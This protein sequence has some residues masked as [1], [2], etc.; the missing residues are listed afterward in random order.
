M[1]LLRRI[2]NRHILWVALSMVA[3]GL[4]VP[5]GFGVKPPQWFH[6]RPPQDVASLSSDELDAADTSTSVASLGMVPKVE[7]NL[8]AD[9]ATQQAPEPDQTSPAQTSQ[10]Q[11]SQNQPSQNQTSAVT[12]P[13]KFARHIPAK[14]FEMTGDIQ[15]E[16]FIKLVLPLILAANEE[17]LQRREAV[18]AAVQA[19]DRDTLVQWAVL[20]RID[21]EDFDD[22]GLA[23]RLLRRVDTI[24]VALALAQA[25]V[26]SGWGTSRF[27]RQGNA[28]FGQWAWTESAGLRP[29]AASN[30]RAVVRSF[31]SL[32]ESVR[33]YMHN[34]NTHQN[35]KRFREARYRLKP[36]AEE[37]KASRL[38]TYL[39]SYA[40]IGQAYV[41]KLLAVMTSNDFDQYAEAKLG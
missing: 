20:Y 5:G 36:Q 31:G 6:D 41:K 25:A 22:V 26:E 7:D 27:A 33:A 38:A 9:R 12:V 17:L 32:L 15:K 2:E 13:S 34:L 8:A 11:A 14:H 18:Q 39:D 23:E 16:S 29:L 4:I 28:L 1:L 37:V 35:Y 24:P 21:S 40:E 3:I 19:N 30:D 10:N